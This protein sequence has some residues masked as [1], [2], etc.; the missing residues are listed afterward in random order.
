MNFKG[1]IITGFVVWLVVVGAHYFL[2]WL[3]TDW[4]TLLIGLPVLLYFSLFPDID[5]QSKVRNW[6]VRGLCT[7]GLIAEYMNS[8]P[9][10]Y[11]I[12]IVLL[13]M[14]TFLKHR[15]ITHTW[16]F[17]IVVVGVLYF[18]FGIEI[19]IFALLGFAAH[20]LADGLLFGK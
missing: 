5:I 20:F 6:T 18:V 17:G 8:R 11:G 7:A 14:F 16:T 15:G 4:L 13:T 12:F 10:V 19:A 1:H 3:E 2:K 9:I